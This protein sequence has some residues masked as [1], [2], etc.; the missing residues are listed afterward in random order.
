EG[1]FLI[2]AG[3]DYIFSTY[4][5]ACGGLV[6]NGEYKQYGG[7]FLVENEFITG[8]SASI[9]VQSGNCTIDAP[10]TGTPYLFEGTMDLNSS[11][12]QF[13][14]NG[15]H[16]P[17]TASLA[18]NATVLSVGGNL[19]IYSVYNPDPST[20]E[21]IGSDDA[22]FFMANGNNFSRLVINKSGGAQVLSDCEVVAN[23]DVRIL[24]GEFYTETNDV[25]A[26]NLLIEPGGFLNAEGSNFYIH[27]NWENNAGDAAFAEY[28][29][30]VRF[31]D[32]FIHGNL[33]TGETF[34]TVTLEKSN[35]ANFVTFAD[36][37]T[38]NAIEMDIESATL[39]TGEN[40]TITVSGSVSVGND[41][42]ID[43]PATASE[44]VFSIGGAITTDIHS[45]ILIETGNMI[46]TAQFY[47]LGSLAINGGEME[48][49]DLIS[50]DPASSTE[51]TDGKLFLSNT[52]PFT[53]NMTGDFTLSD[54]TF[55]AGLN[56][57]EI[58][59]DFNGTLTG[60]FFKTGGNFDAPIVDIFRQDGGQMAFT[61]QG[62]ATINLAEGCYLNE[63][64][65]KNNGLTQLISDVTI[66]DDFILSSGFFSSTN[67]D[68]YIGK[69]WANYP[70]DA[71]TTISGG[72]V[73][74]YSEKPASIPGDETFHTLIIEKT[75]SPGN[76]LEISPGVDI[77]LNKHC[78][79]NDGTLKLNNNASL[80]ISGAL[81]I[82]N[83][84]G[85][86]V[87]DLAG[88]VEI[89]LMSGWDNQNTSNNAYQGFYP[90][91]STVT[92]TGTYPQY[93]NT[94]APREEFYN[95]IIDKLS[96]DFVPNNNINVNNELSIESGIWNY[97]TTG[98]QHQVYGNFTVQPPG[99]WK[100][101]TGYLLLSGPEGT[102]FTNLSPAVSTYGDIEVIPESP[103]DHYYLSG[104]FS[105]SAFYLYE[106]FVTATGLNMQ[107]SDELSISGGELY[108]DGGTA[109]KL[110]NNANLTISGGRLLALGTETQP[111][112]VTRNSIGYY[113][114]NI[115]SNGNLGGEYAIFEYMSGQ[116]VYFLDNAN[117]SQDYP[118][119]FC[120]F[121]N[122]ASGGSLITTESV[123]DIEIASPVFPDNT[124]GSAYNVTKTNN[125]GSITLYDSNGD[126]KG[127]GFEN[128]PYN[129]VNWDVSGFQVQLKAYLEGPY[130]SAGMQTEIASVIPLVQPFNTAPW[131]YSGSES[132]TAIP[133]N[134]VDWILI[135]IR[136]A[137]DAASATEATQLERKAGFLLSDGS[138]VNLDG[139]SSPDFKQIINHNL[140]VIVWHR[141]HL[142]VM[143][144]LA[145]PLFDGTYSY[146]FSSAQSQAFGNVQVYIG[147][148]NFGLVGGDM[149]AD[150]SITDA[151]K[152]G[153]WQIQTGQTGYLQSDADMDG[154]VDNK[155]KNDLWWWNRG[156]F[157]I[158]PE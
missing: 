88:N 151:D 32:Y 11:N 99:G 152:T 66:L 155:D 81:T 134:V 9:I 5:N 50:F 102:T 44:T 29:T 69:D 150:G 65:V 55:D 3:S 117:I 106:G 27:Q 116:G 28:G 19:L 97:G 49:T 77:S 142:P 139:S 143:S 112:L 2:S 85:L 21:F 6:L 64:F 100:D 48:C 129:R 60:G 8:S 140:F 115:V 72:S 89:R 149:N 79:I 154:T 80:T 1:Q 131:N 84:A 118:L 92:F 57:I 113:N 23:E 110:E 132:V 158:I 146:D 75:F 126:F 82:Q 45:D 119:K 33:L 91:T 13:T 125:S 42:N 41:G 20:I 61:S 43:M 67:N 145:L 114:F 94:N 95:L 148:G 39:I 53:L 76:Y 101:D 136:D 51:I 120:T 70:G 47:N 123:E 17:A 130:G 36:D 107:V 38:V 26:L 121:R 15:L 133:P 98:L 83:E 12:F 104:D 108:L 24:A 153:T 54:G 78:L 137:A 68:I 59:S 4:N 156:T 25:H 35:S 30:V 122:G 103:T 56:N 135:E 31:V 73:T 63:C 52:I 62:T 144:N 105:C 138:I 14:N 127:E 22:Y 93:L 74:F 109:L 7:D 90:G 87:D 16:F 96:G 147:D 124:W 141:N 128:D 71:N 37:I 18:T 10:A 46:E 34:H 58:V 40:N 157:I 86:S 111:T